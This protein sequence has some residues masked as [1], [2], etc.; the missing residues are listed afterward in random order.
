MKKSTIASVISSVASATAFERLGKLDRRNAIAVELFAS[1]ANRL[2]VHPVT[3]HSVET[4]YDSRTRNWTTYR[5]D[6]TGWQVGPAEYAGNRFGAAILHVW[7]LS[8]LF[9]FTSR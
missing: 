2:V 8:H 9:N 6:A 5:K 1:K 3:G 4:W 7:A